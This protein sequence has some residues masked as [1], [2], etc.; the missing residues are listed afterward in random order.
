MVDDFSTD[1]VGEGDGLGVTQAH[2]VCY[3]AGDLTGGGAQVVMR[4]MGVSC[5][6]R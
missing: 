5:K 6:F 3:A 4:V 2:S 1:W